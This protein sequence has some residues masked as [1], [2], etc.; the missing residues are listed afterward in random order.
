M[1]IVR[2]GKRNNNPTNTKS[3]ATKPRKQDKEQ[4]SRQGR[5]PSR[6]AG[7]KQNKRGRKEEILQAKPPQA[8][9]PPN[10]SR[11]QKPHNPRKAPKPSKHTRNKRN[12]PKTPL[13][14]QIKAYSSAIAHKQSRKA[15]KRRGTHDQRTTATI[16]QVLRPRSPDHLWTGFSFLHFKNILGFCPIWSPKIP[17]KHQ[18]P[19]K[20]HLL[21]PFFAENLP[22]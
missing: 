19:P 4:E 16:R 13:K 17:R 8:F 22:R 2:K 1:R 15:D 10:Y 9:K 20:N 18:A 21:L 6:R 5:K 3:Q 14:S 11:V 7:R 12:P